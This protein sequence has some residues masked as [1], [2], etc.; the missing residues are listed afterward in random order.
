[1]SESQPT[2]IGDVSFDAAR[3]NAENFMS[4]WCPFVGRPC[5]GKICWGYIENSDPWAETKAKK[6]T[7]GR[8]SHEATGR[9]FKGT[10]VTC[11]FN[12][13]DRMLVHQEEAIGYTIG[14]TGN[15]VNPEGKDVKD[16][17]D[18][19]LER[20]KASADRLRQIL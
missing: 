2:R 18:V 1:L 5:V 15:V 10:I 20:R 13:F 14:P 11:D 6:D 4:R 8:E 12:V 16:D 7:L 17:F 3:E 9:V 19:D